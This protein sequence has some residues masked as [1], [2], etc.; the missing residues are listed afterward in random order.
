M[1]TKQ[2]LMIKGSCLD[3]TLVSLSE[4]VRKPAFH[5]MYREISY[6]LKL[7]FFFVITPPTLSF[8]VRTGRSL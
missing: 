7:F 8:T 4:F 2:I 3:A 5:D 1:I 6:D